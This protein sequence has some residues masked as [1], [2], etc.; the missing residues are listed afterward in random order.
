MM[1]FKQAVGKKTKSPSPYPS[2]LGRSIAT[3]SQGGEGRVR[4]MLNFDIIKLT[5]GI[6]LNRLIAEDQTK[7]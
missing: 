1:N 3:Q 4:G 7:G 2:P 5:K 6:G